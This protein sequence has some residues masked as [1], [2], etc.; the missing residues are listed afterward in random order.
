MGDVAQT[1]GVI[2]KGLGD[3]GGS[4]V[5]QQARLDLMRV[6][7]TKR[8]KF[9]KGEKLMMS[10]GRRDILAALRDDLDKIE[11]HTLA[12]VQ[13]MIVMIEDLE[14]KIPDLTAAQAR[15]NTK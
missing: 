3:K 8:A 15:I 9:T 6:E 13:I 1:A 10:S 7:A 5:L 4:P 2:L 11:A 14:S 12:M